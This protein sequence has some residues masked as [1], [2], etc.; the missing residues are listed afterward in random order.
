MRNGTRKTTAK[1]SGEGSDRG[2]PAAPTVAVGG[3]VTPGVDPELE[4]LILLFAMVAEQ[5]TRAPPPLAEPLH[6]LIVTR[7]DDGV[8]PVAR[9]VRRPRAPPLAEPLHCV[10][11][12]PVVVAGKGSQPVVMPP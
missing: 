3:G 10:I 1:K 7:C 11:V 9:R 4:P 8:V 6:W 12:A 5:M 2:T